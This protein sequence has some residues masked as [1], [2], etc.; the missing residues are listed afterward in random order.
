MTDIKKLNYKTISKQYSMILIG[1]FIFCLGTNI[2]IVPVNLYN[3]GVVG[4]SQLIRTIMTDFLGFSKNIEIVGIINFLL[5][6]PLLILAFSKIS[7]SFFKK[8][9][10][11][12][13]I[14]TLCFTLIPIPKTP[15]ID[16]FLTACIIGGAI[17]G[18]GV[19]I[20][21]R[22]SGCSGGIDILGFYFSSK[23]KN[24]S[25]GKINIIVNAVLYVICGIMFNIQIAIYSVIYIIVFSFIID[26]THS[27]NINTMALV[28]TKCND[29]PERILYEMGRGVTSWNGHGAYTKEETLIF[30]TVISKYEVNQIKEIVYEKDPKA[31]IIFSEGTGVLGNFEKRL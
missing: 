7:K 24:F 3:G 20:I 23:Y 5:N 22:S 14:Q 8:T 10:F 6:I 18:A 4:I 2:F 28:F 19:G 27:Q 1:S 12:I 15:I 29:V 16:D 13:I 9:L 30:V 25:I 17:C 11:S 26:R 21:L 31:F